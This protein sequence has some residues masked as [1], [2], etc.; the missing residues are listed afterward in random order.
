MPLAIEIAGAYLQSKGLG[1]R[2]FDGMSE[3]EYDALMNFLPGRS[4]WSYERGRGMKDIVDLLLDA[5]GDGENDAFRLLTMSSFI[6]PGEIPLWIFSAVLAMEDDLTSREEPGLTFTTTAESQLPPEIHS[7]LKRIRENGNALLASVAKLEELSLVKGVR[8]LDGRILRFSIHN[9]VAKWSVSRL[10]QEARQKIAVFM[11][12]KIVG[13]LEAHRPFPSHRDIDM[14]KFSL[15]Q[16]KLHSDAKDQDLS[17]LCGRYAPQYGW[18]C[19]MLASTCLRSKQHQDARDFY[20]TALQCEAAVSESDQPTRWSRLQLLHDYGILCWRDGDLDAAEDS[21]RSLLESSGPEEGNQFTTDARRYL[22]E[23]P[24]LRSRR[25]ENERQAALAS[26]SAKQEPGSLSRRL[27]SNTAGSSTGFPHAAFT[28]ISTGWTL[29]FRQVVKPVKDIKPVTGRGLSL[30]I[31]L[32]TPNLCLIGSEDEP[33]SGTHAREGQVARVSLH[34]KLRLAAERKASIRSIRMNL[35]AVARTEWPEGIPPLKIEKF[36]ETLLHSQTV[37]LFHPQYNGGEEDRRSSTK[38]ERDSGLADKSLSLSLH[39][40]PWAEVSPE[41][42][43]NILETPRSARADQIQSSDSQV[44]KPGVYEFAFEMPVDRN[45]PE[46]SRLP[47][48]TVKWELTANV[49]MAATLRANLAGAMEISV[50]RVPEEI[51]L[52]TTEHVAVSRSW[53]EQLQYQLLKVKSGFI[54]STIPVLLRLSPL[55]SAQISINRI[56]IIITESV[57]YWTNDKRVKRVVPERK[58]LLCAQRPGESPVD[59]T[60]TTKP[61]TVIA[62]TA[63]EMMG[64]PL[65]MEMRAQIPTCAMMAK[66]A[67]LRLHPSC[68]WKNIKV[69][70]QLVVCV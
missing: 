27:E 66:H 18:L 38:S 47:H 55:N 23:I 59:L 61:E 39:P 10:A 42:L 62:S 5:V 53:E 14:C 63:Q 41:S 32:A 69:S 50:I 48:G 24:V 70:H 8:D 65:E 64:I 16:M 68:G 19:S 4:R 28:P 44:F 33:P 6:G 49:D 46:T 37:I 54:G 67:T 15:Q 36:E 40:K 35:R 1:L 2:D 12:L 52:G 3:S 58:I 9:L 7:W 13:Y 25:A 43:R 31:L 51:R 45:L 57:E 26:Q 34:G 17:V 22:Q 20:A 30:S 60:G 11:A 56:R 29:P 21:F